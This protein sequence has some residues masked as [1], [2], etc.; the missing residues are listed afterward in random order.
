MREIVA[1]SY[2]ATSGAFSAFT[3]AFQVPNL[4]RSLFAD[5][6]L[7]PRS[8]RSS[9]SCSS[10][11][12]ASEAFRLASTLFF[13]I[14]AVARRDH[15]CCSS[16]A[17]RRRH[18]AVHRRQVHR[19]A[20][21]PHGR[22]Q[23]Q[24][25]F[26]I[27][28]LLGLNGLV[29][30]ILNAYD[31]FTIPALAPLV[32]NVVIIVFLVGARPVLR[33]ATTQ[34]YAYAIG[35]LAGTVVQLAMAIP[36]LRRLGFRFQLAFDLRDP[37]VKQVLRADAAGDDRPRA[38]QLQPADQLDARL[39]GLRR[40]R[41]ARSTP[42][43]ASTCCPQGMFSVAIATVLFPALSRFAARSDYDGLRDAAS[44]PACGRSS[45]CSSRRRRRRSSLADADHAADLPARRVRARVDRARVARRCSGSRFS[46]PFAGV[47]PAA[48]A[49]VLQPPAAVDPDR[50]RGPE[51]RRE[52]RGLG[53]ALQAV[54]ASPGIVDRHG[55]VVGGDDRARR[56]TSCAASCTAAST[57]GGRPRSSSQMLGASAL[58]GRGQLRRLGA[59]RRD[60]RARPDRP[61]SCRSASASR[62]GRSSYG[63]T[64]HLLRIP[65]ARQIEHLLAG[66]LLR[67]GER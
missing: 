14:L 56:C 40:R 49:H 4:V 23:P 10:R 43:S 17:R 60:P 26:P 19:A 53:R 65:E 62:R 64:V 54:R 37:R 45:C 66:R 12:S 2:F 33:A 47:E 6:A 32:W 28:V 18:A 61:R 36:V 25:L 44:A 16:L 30:G 48:D 29:V 55:G 63:V 35:V 42:R 41:R 3:I 11:A 13:L 59:A 27:V 34:L 38:H 31:H 50:H 52:R 5:A 46:L 9:P 51:P 22:A 67:R 1:S 21:R 39:A 24:V 57:G 8:C 58:L 7:A 15:A 20:R